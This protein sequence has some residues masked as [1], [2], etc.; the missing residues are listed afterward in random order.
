ME[1]VDEKLNNKL[2]KVAKPTHNVSTIYKIFFFK[3]K[4]IGKCTFQ[5]IILDFFKPVQHS[6]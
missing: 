6:L 5:T 4:T 2:K 1:S 3:K